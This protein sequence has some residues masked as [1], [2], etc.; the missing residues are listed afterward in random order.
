MCR[1]FVRNSNAWGGVATGA[2]SSTTSMSASI[3]VNGHPL[4]LELVSAVVKCVAS[5]YDV[6]EGDKC[7]KAVSESLGDLG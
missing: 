3:T 4:T 1:E 7:V 5:E 2:V 6:D